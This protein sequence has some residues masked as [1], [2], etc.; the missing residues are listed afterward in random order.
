MPS[1][2]VSGMM[3]QSGFATAGYLLFWNFNRIELVAAALVV[4][5]V[6]VVSTQMDVARWRRGAVILSLLL[7]A[8]SLTETYLLTPQMCATGLHLNLFE[9]A[10][11]V[12]TTMNQLHVV[13][14]L[15]EVFKF[16]AGGALLGWCFRQLP[17]RP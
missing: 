11:E 7:L 14:W 15:L 4:A 1:L 8:V 9:S 10:V 12:P 16:V 13:Y 2:Y 6:L 17:L 3:T 5:G